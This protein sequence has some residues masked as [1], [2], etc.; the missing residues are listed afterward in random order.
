MMQDFLPPQRLLLRPGSS[1]VDVRVLQAMA[2]PLIAPLDPAEFQQRAQPCMQQ[3]E[4]LA[5][6]GKL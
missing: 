6:M 4:S 1:L 5:H 2:V 3:P